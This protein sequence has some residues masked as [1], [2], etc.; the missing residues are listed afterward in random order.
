MDRETLAFS[1]PEYFF[2]EC[3]DVPPAVL[4]GQENRLDLVFVAVGVISV[5]PSVR[6]GSEVAAAD[7]GPGRSTPTGR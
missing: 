1:L 5:S 3:N 7:P 4:V 6:M 2:A